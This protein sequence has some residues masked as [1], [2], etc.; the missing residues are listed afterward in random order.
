MNQYFFDFVESHGGD[1]VFSEKVGV[2]RQAIGNIKRGRNKATEKVLSAIEKCFPDFDRAK[3][4]SYD[5]VKIYIDQIAVL[6]E[7]VKEL[8][9]R[10]KILEDTQNSIIGS[11]VRGNMGKI[12]GVQSSLLTD[13][14]MISQ[15]FHQEWMGDISSFR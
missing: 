8:R 7:E 13:N 14:L 3:Y 10:N 11:M 12:D 4:F 5:Y 15:I 2:T 6:N 1:N 9:L